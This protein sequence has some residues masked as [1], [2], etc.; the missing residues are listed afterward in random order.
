MEESKDEADKAHA[1]AKRLVQRGF[2]IETKPWIQNQ[3]QLI[4]YGVSLSEKGDNLLYK[5]RHPIWYFIYQKL[6]LSLGIA[7]ISFIVNT[8]F[9]RN[10]VDAILRHLLPV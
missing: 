9:I 3:Y 6:V 5:L 4:M 1:A 7:T 10:Y 8:V 2:L